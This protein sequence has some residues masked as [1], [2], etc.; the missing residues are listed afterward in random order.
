MQFFRNFTGFQ[1]AFF[2][3]FTAASIITFLLPVLVLGKSA[4]SV[5]SFLGILGLISTIAGILVSIYTAKASISGYVWWWINTGT[6]AIIALA[7]NLYGQFIKNFLILLPLQVYGFIAWRRNMNANKSEDI[8]IRKFTKKETTIYLAIT[9]VCFVCYGLFINYLPNIM[10]ALFKIQIPADPQVFLDAFTS[11][12]TIMAVYLTGKRFVE[13]WYYWLISNTLG[14]IM[15]V[16]QTIHAGVHDPSMFVGDVSN[17]ISILQYGV[18]A[19]YGFILWRT[20]Y[21]QRKTESK[22]QTVA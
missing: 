13:Q 8:A 4:S 1:K 19:I 5:F 15:F 2:L 16:I 21:K 17:T 9:V 14:V 11:T 22:E 12:L 18:G 10:N 6:F 20:M 3:F 7:G